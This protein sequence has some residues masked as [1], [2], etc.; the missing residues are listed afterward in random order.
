ML[1]I[2]ITHRIELS[3]DTKAFVAALFGSKPAVQPVTPSTPAKE[4]KPL[5]KEATPAQPKD[6]PVTTEDQGTDEVETAT[7]T[8]TATATKPAISGTKLVELVA[9]TLRE[10]EAAGD[11]DFKA[12]L[13]GL[14]KNYR[15]SDGSAPCKAIS[16]IHED[17]IADFLNNL[18]TL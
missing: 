6:E 12:R 4:V 1:E 5:R 18:K 7:T 13:G 9:Q 15:N 14:L 17:D 2:T 10:K 8:S 16:K 11:N 3:E